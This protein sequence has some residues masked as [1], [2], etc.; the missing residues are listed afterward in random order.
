M[1][2]Q[3]NQLW[4]NPNKRRYYRVML[5]HDLFDSIVLHCMWGGL[6][7]AKGGD[8]REV[9]SDAETANEK[10][11]KIRKRRQQHGYHLVKQK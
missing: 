11:E 8:S 10:L 7:S 1:E 2:S 3:T 4:I 9:F 5:S 6:D